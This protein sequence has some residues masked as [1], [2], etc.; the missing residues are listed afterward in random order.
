MYSVQPY[1]TPYMEEY[2]CMRIRGLNTR[3]PFGFLR[4]LP[5]I[6]FL[7]Y[8]GIHT[9]R[10]FGFFAYKDYTQLYTPEYRII[11]I[12]TPAMEV[13]I[14]PACRVC[15]RRMILSCTVTCTARS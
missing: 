12:M 3:S 14:V 5:F 7:S 9:M 2:S 8:I 1:S 10:V 6:L 13:E 11:H 15:R 4:T